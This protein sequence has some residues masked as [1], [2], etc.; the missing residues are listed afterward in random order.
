M[1]ELKLIDLSK[2]FGGTVAVQ[3]TTL[4]IHNGEFVTLLGPSGCGKTTTLRMIAGFTRPTTGD[5]LLDDQVITSVEKKVFLPPDKRKMGMVFQSYAVWPHMEVFAN[6][7]YP[8]KFKKLPK[9]E[10][11]KRVK[12]ALALVKL[13]GFEARYP[14]QLSGGQQQRVAL[15]RALIMEPQ[16]LL[17]DE[18][19][20]NLDAKLREGMRFEIVEL[21]RRLKI[22][23]IYVTHDQAEAMSMSDRII[24]MHN[25]KVLQVDSPRQVYESP[26]NEFV[27]GFIGLA[28]FIPCTV[29]ERDADRVRVH[30]EDGIPE[31]FLDCPAPA[32]KLADYTLLVVRPEHIKLLPHQSDG[33]RGLV[34]RQTYLGDR[35]DYL[36]Q[37]GDIQLRAQTESHLNFAPGQEVSVVFTQ[38]TLLKQ[39]ET[40]PRGAQSEALPG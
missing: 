37:L 18:P 6:V 39:Q 35:T 27:A 15:A 32:D 21:Q 12:Q 10:V 30:L 1:A 38:S 5:I 31:H 9:K 3:E 2:S 14:H 13:D 26:V 20:S 24:V 36:I 23:V 33:V 29:L 4:T 16:V 19:L 25:G 34:L 17:L 28:N 7:A 22:T 8:L 11:T 40:S